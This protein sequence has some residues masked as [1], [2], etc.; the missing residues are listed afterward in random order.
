LQFAVGEIERTNGY[1]FL[2]LNKKEELV[3]FFTIQMLL[4][5]LIG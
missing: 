1:Y 4:D 2:V 3:G 5:Y